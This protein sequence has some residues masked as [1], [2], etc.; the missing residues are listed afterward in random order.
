MAIE[1]LQQYPDG[2]YDIE[3][4]P[5]VEEGEVIKIITR[6]PFGEDTWRLPKERL[7]QVTRGKAKWKIDV[8]KNLLKKYG[9]ETVDPAPTGTV[10]TTITDL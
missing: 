2:T 7:H 9:G 1:D 5:P 3:I 6:T 10:T 8:K 4:E